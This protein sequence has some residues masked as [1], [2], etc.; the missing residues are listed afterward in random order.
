MRGNGRNRVDIDFS[1]SGF[2]SQRK[3]Y[4]A[5]RAF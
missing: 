5:F 4:S 1:L 2:L 3:R